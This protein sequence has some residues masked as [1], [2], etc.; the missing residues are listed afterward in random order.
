[1]AS[2]YGNRRHSRGGI[3]TVLDVLLFLLT[4]VCGLLLLCVYL[5]RFI[6]PADAWFFS[7]TALLAPVLF[8]AN[9]LLALYWCVRWRV[10]AFISLGA[11]LIGVG[12]LSLFFKP[13]FGQSY[14]KDPPRGAVTVV[15]HNVMG[16][17]HRSPDGKLAWSPGG[18]TDFFREAAPDILCL[19]EFQCM[20]GEQKAIIDSLIDLPYNRVNYRIETAA[21]GGWGVAIYSRYPIIRYDKLNFQQSTNSAIW[22]DVVVGRDTLRVFSN[23]LQTTS[24]DKT[25]RDYINNH[26]FLQNPQRREE[27]VRGI[28]S[29]LRRNFA[30][31]AEQAD[32]L[33][34]IIDASPYRVAVCG[35]FNDTPMSYTYFRIRDGLNDAFVEKGEGMASNTFRGLFNMFRIDYVLCSPE[36]EVLSYETTDTG[37]SDHKAVTTRI[38]PP[39]RR[40]KH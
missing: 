9:I 34:Q 40:Q 27:V 39:S 8:V 13:V 25:E 10:W 33:A 29:K 1:M 36:I 7:F 20:N 6:H 24:V 2:S 15:T 28:A 35:D 18:T 21:G 22:C 16:F 30:L 37:L 31:R 12:Y 32:T 5:A 19:Q 26:E 3:A 4:I 11:L 23:H 17:L 14:P 38:L